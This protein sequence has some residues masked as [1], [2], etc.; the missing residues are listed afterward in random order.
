VKSAGV[1]KDWPQWASNAAAGLA[2]IVSSS[3]RPCCLMIYGYVR[4]STDGQT[5]A[6]QVNQ[7]RDAGAVKVARE[8]AGGAKSDRRALLCLLAER[9]LTASPDRRATC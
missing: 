5:L 2:A 1:I 9:G 4:D 7:L 3:E 6:A 8:K